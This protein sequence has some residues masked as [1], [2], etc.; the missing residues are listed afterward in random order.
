MDNYTGKI[1]FFRCEK[2]NYIAVAIPAP[3][4]AHA[5]T[6]GYTFLGESEVINVQL[7]GQTPAEK[8]ERLEDE[9][10]KT[11]A[12]SKTLIDVIAGKIQK[13]RDSEAPE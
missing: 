9:I 12:A 6:D 13:L 8:I 5:L 10:T 1:Q 4:G 2:F 7:K 3:D 11:E